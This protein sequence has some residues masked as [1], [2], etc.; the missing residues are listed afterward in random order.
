[1]LCLSKPKAVRQQTDA[2][3]CLQKIIS[4]TVRSLCF[5]PTPSIK[6]DGDD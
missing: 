3:I 4:S 1:V 5:L 2:K 6:P